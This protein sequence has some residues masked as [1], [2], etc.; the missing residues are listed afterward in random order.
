[1]GALLFAHGVLL[2][3]AATVMGPL[4]VLV[5]PGYFWLLP[6]TAALMLRGG[7]A[8]RARALDARADAKQR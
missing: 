3:I 7:A 6:M 1:M 2:R 8:A 5:S 4:M